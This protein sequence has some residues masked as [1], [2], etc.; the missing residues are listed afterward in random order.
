MQIS[1]F[2]VGHDSRVADRTDARN[3]GGSRAAGDLT[4]GDA[5]AVATV[6]HRPGIGDERLRELGW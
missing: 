1:Q 2:R 3:G 4:V 6:W 5:G